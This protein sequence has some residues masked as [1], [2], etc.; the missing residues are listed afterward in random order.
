MSLSI[1]ADIKAM[2]YTYPIISVVF[3][4]AVGG[5]GLLMMSATAD[6][7]DK[8]AECLKEKTTDC[9]IDAPCCLKDVKIYNQNHTK[10]A[11]WERKEAIAFGL[12]K[13]DATINYLFVAVAGIFVFIGKIFIEPKISNQN[14]QH[15]SEGLIFWIANSAVAC[16]FSVGFGFFARLYFNNIGDMTS[17]SIYGELGVGLFLQ[18]LLFVLAFIF[19]AIATILIAKK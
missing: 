13:I 8:N 4:L 18:L 7:N 15:L 5:G 12:E 1:I 2:K 19:V 16:V 9:V 14:V 17:F 3:W 6:Y 10:Y 11:E